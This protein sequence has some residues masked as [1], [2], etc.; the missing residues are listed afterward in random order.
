MI[1]MGASEP[2]MQKGVSLGL[3]QAN[4]KQSQ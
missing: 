3:L 1:A 4:E 2:R